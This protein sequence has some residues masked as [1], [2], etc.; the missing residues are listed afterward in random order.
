M[1]SAG[2]LTPSRF[3]SRP[4]TDIG[5]TCVDRTGIL[6]LIMAN[7]SGENRTSQEFAQTIH[8][9]VQTARDTALK[10]HQLFVH[11]DH[12]AASEFM[13]TADQLNQILAGLNR[14]SERSATP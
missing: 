6:G 2:V 1:E 11:S 12:K 4:A 10:A 8:V 13:H 7:E 5:V 3:K 14:M 9:E